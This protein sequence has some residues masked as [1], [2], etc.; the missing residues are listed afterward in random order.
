MEKHPLPLVLTISKVSS[1]FIAS[2]VKLVLP[3][4]MQ[5]GHMFTEPRNYHRASRIQDTN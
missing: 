3:Q 4:V 1:K 5:T 2:P